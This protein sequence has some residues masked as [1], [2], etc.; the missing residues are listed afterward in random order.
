MAAGSQGPAAC[1][2]WT[3][4]RTG[5]WAEG[6]AT[7]ASMALWVRNARLMRAG[8]YER[9]HGHAHRELRS[10]AC[11]YDHGNICKN[12]S[13]SLSCTCHCLAA[14]GRGSVNSHRHRGLE[15]QRPISQACCQMCLC[16]SQPAESGITASG[17]SPHTA[18][19]PD[20]GSR[21]SCKCGS[22]QRM[23]KVETTLSCQLFKAGLELST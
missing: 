9:L 13:G 4:W 15:L 18:S 5:C 19:M 2:C 20:S 6:S 14:M 7:S 3:S 22:D 11:H 16:H 17:C 23:L 10:C 12:M 8:L 1:R 21:M